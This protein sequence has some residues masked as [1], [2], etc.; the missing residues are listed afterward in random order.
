MST[1]RFSAVGPP[2]G[3]WTAHGATPSYPQP[4]T[5]G[6]GQSGISSTWVMPSPASSPSRS[7]AASRVPSR[8][9]VP[10]WSSYRTPARSRSRGDSLN[11]TYAE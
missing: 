9:K 1:N 4:R 5:P 3:S 6:K 7:A 10:M 11:Q 8:V 2:Y